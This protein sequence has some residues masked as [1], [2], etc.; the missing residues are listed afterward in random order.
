M[1]AGIYIIKNTKNEKVYV[2]SSVDVDLRLL[3]HKCMLEKN[4]HYNKKLQ[5]AWNKYGEGNFSFFPICSVFDKSHLIQLEQF[6]IDLMKSAVKGYN[7]CPKAYSTLGAP[8]RGV[9]HTEETKRKI[10]QTL[11][12]RKV[13][14]HVLVKLRGRK[15][16]EETKAKLQIKMT[17]NK[18]A[19]GPHVISEELREKMRQNGRAH[20]Y[21]LGRK[22]SE[23]TKKK[24]SEA[25]AR[26]WAERHELERMK[27]DS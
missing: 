26:I 8:K 27:Y 15:C 10:S 4:I 16:S 2:G 25:H 17:G 12:G 1:N 3:D 19:S 22:A 11:K 23:E 24:M 5:N 20:K 14:E 21:L 6:H 7:I 18:F 13:P 9:R